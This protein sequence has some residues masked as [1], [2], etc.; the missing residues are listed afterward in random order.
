M[1]CSS[2]AP[3]TDVSFPSGGGDYDVIWGVVD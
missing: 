3:A 1:V 2:S